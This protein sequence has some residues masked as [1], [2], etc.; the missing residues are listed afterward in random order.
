[1][2]PGFQVCGSSFNSLLDPTNLTGFGAAIQLCSIVKGFL[3]LSLKDTL[4]LF[5]KRWHFFQV[6]IFYLVSV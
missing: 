6:A 1:M 5:V 3:C 4:R 2:A